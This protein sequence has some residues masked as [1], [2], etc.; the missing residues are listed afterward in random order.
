MA[1]GILEEKWVEPTESRIRRRNRADWTVTQFLLFITDPARV[2]LTS[3]RTLQELL[4]NGWA[5]VSACPL[6]SGHSGRRTTSGIR[7]RLTGRSRGS[8]LRSYWSSDAPIFQP[9]ITSAPIHTAA[10]ERLD[11]RQARH[12]SRIS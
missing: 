7:G 2:S 3:P 10:S 8:G 1:L 5:V 6:G 4:R 9:E 12:P 11:E